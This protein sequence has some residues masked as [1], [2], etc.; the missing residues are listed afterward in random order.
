ME[1]QS[2]IYLFVDASFALYTRIAI[3][4]KAGSYSEFYVVGGGVHPVAN[5]MAMAYFRLR[6]SDDTIK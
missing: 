3:W 2:L 1:L 5:G 6:R 4:S